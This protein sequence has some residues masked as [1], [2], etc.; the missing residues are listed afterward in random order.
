M[1]LEHF[2]SYKGKHELVKSRSLPSH[3]TSD[4]AP[5]DVNFENFHVISGLVKTCKYS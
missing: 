2:I 3:K 1:E 4:L 5:T